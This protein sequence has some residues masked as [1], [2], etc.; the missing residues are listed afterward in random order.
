MSHCGMKMKDELLQHHE[1]SLRN[2]ML[3]FSIEVKKKYNEMGEN[4]NEQTNF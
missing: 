3:L 2:N 1:V 4:E